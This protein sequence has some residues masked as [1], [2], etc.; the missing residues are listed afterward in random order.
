MSQSD[1]LP[2]AQR[3]LLE[4][5]ARGLVSAIQSM[6][7]D[8]PSCTVGGPS[9]QPSANDDAEV[10]VYEVNLTK[11][12]ALRIQTPAG[13]WKDIAG[14]VLTAVGMES[15]TDQLC[16]ETYRETIGQAV[17]LLAQSISSRL[18]KEVSF[19]ATQSNAAV[20]LAGSPLAIDVGFESQPP[21]S[22]AVSTSDSLVELL[23]APE[24]PATPAQPRADNLGSLE[25]LEMS[26]TVSLGTARLT[27][28]DAVALGPGSVVQLS[29]KLDDPVLVKVDGKVVAIGEVVA[30]ENSYAIRITKLANFRAKASSC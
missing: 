8:A 2:T 9:A 22:L 24:A 23:N 30:V 3:W 26:V 25:E 7:C 14:R 17:S 1:T 10:L 6:G 21:H 18:K 4:E 12:P 19:A 15:P 28:A 27:V 16:L 29:S 20:S 5:F 11:A 13:A